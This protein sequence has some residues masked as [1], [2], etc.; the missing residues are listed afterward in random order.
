[1]TLADRQ[2]E[3]VAPY[4]RRL[5]GTEGVA[6]MLTSLE[7]GCTFVSY[8]PRLKVPSG[9]A[10]YRFIESAANSSCTTTGTSSTRS[11]GR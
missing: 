4:Y 1:L 8:V 11:W 7:Q 9:D 6:R 3:L 2:A 5:K 10:N